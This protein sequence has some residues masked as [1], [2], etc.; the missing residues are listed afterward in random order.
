MCG[1]GTRMDVYENVRKENKRKKSPGLRFAVKTRWNSD[2]DETMRASSNQL[3]LEM[4]MDRL[5]CRS[6]IDSD[7]FKTNEGDISKVLPQPSDY[8]LW[9]QYESA[10]QPLKQYSEFSQSAKVIFH[11][12]LF[13]GKMAMERLG[14]SFFTMYQNLSTNIVGGGANL[15]NRPFNQ[16]VERKGFTLY[17]GNIED[18]AKIKGKH[19]MRNEIS[20]ARRVGFRHLGVRLLF[21][22]RMDTDDNNDINNLDAD[23]TAELMEGLVDSPSLPEI[24]IMGAIIHPLFQNEAR[25]VGSGL[26][27][28]SQYKAGFAELLDRITRAYESMGGHDEVRA[29]VSISTISNQRGNK[30]DDSNENAYQM[31]PSSRKAQDELALFDTYKR[32][33]FQPEL[34]PTKTL[35]AFDADGQPQDPVFSIGAV[36]K[37]GDDLPT[38]F[39][40]ADYIDGKG[41]YDI[42]SFFKD[43]ENKFPALFKVGVGQLGPHITTEVD[44]ES[45]FSQAGHLSDPLRNRTKTEN[46]ER[47]VMA[48]HRMTRMYCCPIKVRNEFM[49]R[50]KAK[51]WLDGEDRDDIEFW[52]QEKQRYLNEFPHNTGVFEDDGDGDDAMD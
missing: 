37:R 26:C 14:S 41:N 34:H 43:H 45:L 18:A 11:M 19:E 28:E 46:F 8:E 24:K 16:L 21:F 31:S 27:T 33:K 47:L 42:V 17:H 4:A 36:T 1:S 10:L 39:N 5:V 20:V 25:M 6:G 52:E 32:G 29:Q 44:C 7:I 2:H 22:Q 38:G 3:D 30:W 50:F 49:D 48:K 40:H 23:I 9:Q 12:E 51:R 15:S 13:E 35:G